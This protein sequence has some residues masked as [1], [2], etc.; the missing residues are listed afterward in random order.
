MHAEKTDD[1]GARARRGSEGEPT[2]AELASLE[3]TGIAELHPGSQLKDYIYERSRRLFAR[4]DAERDALSTLAE[5]R[6]RQSAV[7]DVLLAGLGGLPPSDTPLQSQCMGTVKGRGFSVEKVVFQSRP[8]HYVTANLYLPDDRPA[9]TAAVVFLCGHY[10]EAKQHPEYQAVCQTLVHAGLIVLAVDPIGQGE[11]LGYFDPQRGATLV[12]AGTAEHDTAGT[13]CRLLGDGLARY[14]LH[15]AMRAVDFLLARPDVDPARIG[16]TGNSGGGTQTSLMMMADPRI[17]AAAPGTFITSRDAY[18]RTGQAQDAEQIWAG[19]TGAGY[20]HEDILLAMAPRPVCVLAATF[21][22]F[23]IEG[24]RRTVGR[25]R[26]VW[27]L[28]GAGDA[29]ELAED[30][31]GHAYTP[32]LARAAARFFSRRLLGATK[33]PPFLVPEVYPAATLQVTRT[34]QVAGDFPDAEFVF[35][36]TTGRRRSAEAARRS[37]GKADAGDWLRAQVFRGREACEPNPRR[38]S[39]AMPVGGLEVEAA[40]WW[41]QPG[42]ANLGLLFRPAGAR[43]GRPV[44]VAVW[45]GGTGA[46]SAHGRWLADE[47]ARGNAVFVVSL[48]GVGPLQPDPI[49]PLPVEGRFGTL[50]KLAEDLEWMGD[51]LAALR[52]HEVI[53]AVDALE[54]AWPELRGM[55]MR[56]YAQG[57]LGVYGRLAAAL[58]PRLRRC[59]WHAGFRFADLAGNRLYDTRGV[60][61]IVLPGVLRHFDLDEL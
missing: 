30:R 53:R 55:A 47:C 48:C 23:P 26:R 36:A 31:A 8:R 28:L 46:L 59:E 17:A 1:T 60:K 34:G 3:T 39:G 33:E 43:G 19:F 57:R 11:R 18:Q 52:T 50:H 45:D 40:W 51:S 32:A 21:D 38:A 2:P 20:D 6:R 54:A 5:V 29:L 15:D 12:G 42:L 61:E 25:C 35:D 37:R 16:V 44:T 24:T 58:D 49:S 22:F 4:G 41:S 10:D 56:L 7:R 14:F 27:D 13:Q 9:R